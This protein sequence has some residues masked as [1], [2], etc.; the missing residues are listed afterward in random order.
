[1]PSRI[2]NSRIRA[3]YVGNM[4][5]RCRVD[6]RAGQAGSGITPL[7]YQGLLLEL[8]V[9]HRPDL[10]NCSRIFPRKI[11]ANDDWRD[12]SIGI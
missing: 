1:M 3:V 9:E 5:C 6:H 11:E 10:F 8:D 12:R 2:A 4:N 7:L